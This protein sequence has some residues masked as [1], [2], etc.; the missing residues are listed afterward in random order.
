MIRVFLC[1]TIRGG[2]HIPVLP[3]LLSKAAEIKYCAL[4]ALICKVRTPS[5]LFFI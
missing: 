1:L 4:F 5:R 3:V 2:E